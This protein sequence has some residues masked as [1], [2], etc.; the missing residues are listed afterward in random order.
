VLFKIGPLTLHTYGFFVALGF[1]LGLVWCSRESRKRQLDPEI[2]PDLF[3][4]VVIAALVG[5]RLLYVVLNISYF[6]RHPLAVFKIWEGGLVFYGGF[7]AA[8]PVLIWRIRRWRRPA[9]EILD[10]AAPGLVLAQAVGRLGCLSAGCCYGRACSSRI[11][12]VFT[13]P[14]SHAPLHQPLYPTQLF[15]AAADLF[16]FLVLVGLSRKA[17]RPGVVAVCYLVLYGVLR[18]TV[19]FWRGDPRGF[20]AGLSTSQWIS[21]VL[22]GCGLL[23]WFFKVGRETGD[24]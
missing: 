14:L 8:V 18:F 2:I 6:S 22:I 15:H 20:F 23:L 17:S 7:L 21:L 5:A 24:V 3:F 1:L 16:I 4:Y 12:I 10:V 13:S 19:E 11:G 9:L